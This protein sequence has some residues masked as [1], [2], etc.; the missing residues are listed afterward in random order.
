MS[1]FDKLFG[2]S[3]IKSEK[4]SEKR[5]DIDKLLLSENKNNSIIEL[6]NYICELCDWGEKLD[7]LT[8]EQKNFFFNQNLEREINNGGFNQYFY[9]SSGDFAHET[10]NS[11]KII[12]ADKTANILQQAI[13]QFPDK[14]VPLNRTERQEVLEK[15]EETVSEIFEELDEKFFVYE[16]DLNTLNIEFV[17]QNKDKF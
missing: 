4:T 16:D 11:L 1:I 8:E 17:R 3:D 7:N 2:K 12:G 5:L 13:D 10:I 14:I 15:I 9:N 6:D